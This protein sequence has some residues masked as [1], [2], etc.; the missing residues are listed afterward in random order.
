MKIITD[1]ASINVKDRNGL[2]VIMKACIYNKF[3]IIQFLADEFPTHLGLNEK[4]NEG[5]TALHHACKFGRLAI[6]Q[7]LLG[8][9]RRLHVD[10]NARNNEGQTPIDVALSSKNKCSANMIMEAGLSCG[11]NFMKQRLATFKEIKHYHRLL[12]IVEINNNTNYSEDL[13]RIS[14]KRSCK[15]PDT[16]PRISNQHLIAGTKSHY[17]GNKPAPCNYNQLM[18]SKVAC[19]KL[20]QLS[21]IQRSPSY[22]RSAPPFVYRRL[23]SNS[24]HG[25]SKSNGSNASFRSNHT[26]TH[27][28]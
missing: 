27:V 24:R 1:P 20:L 25:S 3:D 5:N 14:S 15:V 8:L 12:E 28:I 23:A 11:Y 26:D 7:K 9:M 18:S 19:S 17:Q 10:M 2:T 22:C 16:L 13:L 4:D 6:V 21:A